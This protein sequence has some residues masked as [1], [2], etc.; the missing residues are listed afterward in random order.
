VST[1]H[2]FLANHLLKEELYNPIPP[3]AAREMQDLPQQEE[4]GPY[5]ADF[6]EM[7]LRIRSKFQEIGFHR[8]ER[9]I[10]RSI[11]PRLANRSGLSP[12]QEQPIYGHEK[13]L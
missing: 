13:Y 9:L 3:Q 1:G 6:E 4:L 12:A 5:L 2:C 8:T 10:S 11:P 7:S